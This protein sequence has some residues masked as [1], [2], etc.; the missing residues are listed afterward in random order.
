MK[1][2]R[3]S[4][5]PRIVLE[6]D[7][8]IQNESEKQFKKLKEN[9]EELTYMPLKYGSVQFQKNFR[10]LSDITLTGF[11]IA[12][13]KARGPTMTVQEIA[14]EVFQIFSALR[15]VSGC[16]YKGDLIHTINGCLKTNPMFQKVFKKSKFTL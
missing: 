16:K 12:L 5:L 11:I 15:K 8:H 9:L 2:S 7:T 14:S 4:K 1:R 3:K 10:V 6:K 13:M